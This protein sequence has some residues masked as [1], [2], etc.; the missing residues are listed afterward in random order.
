MTHFI[1]AR[2]FGPCHSQG[3]QNGE[4]SHSTALYPWIPGRRFAR[5]CGSLPYVR[6]PRHSLTPPSTRYNTREFFFVRTRRSAM[7]APMERNQKHSPDADTA[8]D[9]Q[10]SPQAGRA[11]EKN[12]AR[13]TSAGDAPRAI[14]P[15]VANLV[16]SIFRDYLPGQSLRTIA[17]T[18]NREGI[19]G[20]QC[21]K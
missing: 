14:K 11:T 8:R 7:L 20:P 4:K 18:L 9:A 13:L 16:G 5:R 15:A 19:S 3:P 1:Q 6:P 12:I 17:M 10:D 21:K 2:A